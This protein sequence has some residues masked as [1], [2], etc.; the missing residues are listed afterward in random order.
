M[1][2]KLARREGLHTTGG[3]VQVW[4]TEVQSTFCKSHLHIQQTNIAKQQIKQ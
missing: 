4:L 3:F 2:L 1:V